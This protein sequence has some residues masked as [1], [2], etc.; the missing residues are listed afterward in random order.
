M[1]VPLSLLYV[2]SVLIRYGRRAI[3]HLDSLL[4]CRYVALL[5]NV[6]PLTGWTGFIWY[7]LRSSFNN[8]ANTQL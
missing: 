6:Y 8:P 4:L 7:Y 2:C 3:R 1:K 5:L